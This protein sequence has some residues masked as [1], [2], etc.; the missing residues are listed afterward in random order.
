MHIF[1]S[2]ESIFVT[3]DT[4]DILYLVYSNFSTK[5]KVRKVI[6]LDFKYNFIYSKFEQIKH[7]IYIVSKVN[8]NRRIQTKN[9][10][11]PHYYYYWG[12]TT[13]RW[14]NTDTN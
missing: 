3:L 1:C 14:F 10:H 13:G 5:K 9:M 7:K 2:N 6:S 12:L 4:I 11:M 8:K